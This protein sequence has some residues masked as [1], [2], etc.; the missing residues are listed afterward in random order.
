LQG[1][2]LGLGDLPAEV[3]LPAEAPRPGEEP[4]TDGFRGLLRLT[5]Q[6]DV[7]RLTE[8]LL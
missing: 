8:T 2:E 3:I 6:L 1:A 7:F 4:N 5:Q